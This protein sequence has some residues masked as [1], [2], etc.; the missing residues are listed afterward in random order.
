MKNTKSIFKNIFVT[1]AFIPMLT[2]CGEIIRLANFIGLI[3][4]REK[5]IHLSFGEQQVNEPFT[6]ADYCKEE[7]DTIFLL[8]SYFNTSKADFI[9]LEMSPQ[10]RRIC[11]SNVMLDTFNTLLFIKDGKVLAY[12]KV[13]C[14]DADFYS[15]E[16]EKH[17]ILPFHQKFMMDNERN[18]HIYNK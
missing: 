1:I 18:I 17:Y 5:E 7:S 16:V 14:I 13:A 4:P 11:E 9:N 15:S 2:S 10:L 3:P 6:L 8:Y 12:C